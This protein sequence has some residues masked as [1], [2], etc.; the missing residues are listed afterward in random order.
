M[1][2]VNTWMFE[3]IQTDIYN[4]QQQILQITQKSERS[5]T[6]G[7]LQSYSYTDRPLAATGGVTTNTQ[8]YVDLIFCYDARKSGEGAGMGTGVPAYYDPVVDDY[9]RFEDN[10]ILSV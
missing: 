1:T 2:N 5:E 10:A 3:Q 7:G 8:S 4:L 6:A 9:R